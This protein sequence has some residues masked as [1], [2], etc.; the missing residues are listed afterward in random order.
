[1]DFLLHWIAASAVKGTV[2]AIIFLVAQVLFSKHMKPRWKYFIWLLVA[3]RL[4]MPPVFPTDFSFYNLEK[5]YGNNV[6]KA[7]PATISQTIPGASQAMLMVYGAFQSKTNKGFPIK[8]L[9]FATW[10][11]GA[12]SLLS[13]VLA[14]NWLILFKIRRIQPNTQPKYLALLDDCK[15]EFKI[16]SSVP[17]IETNIINTPALFGVIR[18][19]LLLPEGLVD[20][21]SMNELRQIFI[22]EL[23]HLKR[24]DI[25][26]N[27]LVTFIQVIQ[28]FNPFAWLAFSKLREAREEA[29]DEAALT[30]LGK[31]KSLQYGQTI[32]KLLQF[33]NPEKSITGMVGVLEDNKQIARRLK[34]IKSFHRSSKSAT[35]FS[36][37][38]LIFTGTVFL[39]EASEVKAYSKKHAKRKLVSV[40]RKDLKV[41]S[42]SPLIKMEVLKTPTSFNAEAPLPEKPLDT[43]EILMKKLESIVLPN[44]KIEEM[45]LPAALTFLE[46]TSKKHDPD[47]GGVGFA[48]RLNEEQYTNIPKISIVSDNIT[49]KTAIKNICESSDLKWD[50]KKGVI[51]IYPHEEQSS[52]EALA[53]K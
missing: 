45:E 53:A 27:W 43:E 29:C 20:K 32:I 10:F 35:A 42:H 12:F 22:H 31:E 28:W 40:I 7:V 18:P 13:I 25:L 48:L 1:M 14:K 6:N 39:T 37:F 5:F 46:E 9:L 41:V 26:I 52:T 3:A 47:G 17:L 8:H 49:L 11:A 24:M 38:T 16:H 2:L 4:I 15:R 36:L 23:I 19:R 21:I 44:I 51:H 34:M 33:C 50:I 30:F